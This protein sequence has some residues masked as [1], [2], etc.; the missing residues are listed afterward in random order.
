MRHCK[1]TC[2]KKAKLVKS[3]PFTYY[4][5]YYKLNYLCGVCGLQLHCI[6]QSLTL[7]VMVCNSIVNLQRSALCITPH[8]YLICCCFWVTRPWYWWGSARRFPKDRGAKSLPNVIRSAMQSA[9]CKTQYGSGT[10]PPILLL[11]YRI[12]RYFK[13]TRQPQNRTWRHLP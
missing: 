12:N 4:I 8:T 2:W 10:F 11:M 13:S 5:F 3:H 1:K 9:N 7:K 6:T